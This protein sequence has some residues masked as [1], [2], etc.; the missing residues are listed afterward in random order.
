MDRLI[1]EKK[2]LDV[3]NEAIRLGRFYCGKEQTIREIKAIPSEYNG[4]E[5]CKYEHYTA[6]SIPCS[7]CKHSYVGNER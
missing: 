3:I 6:S 4:C 1:S 5:N 2:V 7:I